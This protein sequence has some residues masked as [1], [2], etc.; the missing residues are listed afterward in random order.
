MPKLPKL[1]KDVLSV[2]EILSRDPLDELNKIAEKL[3]PDELNQGE[4]SDLVKMWIALKKRSIC[5]DTRWIYMFLH[6]AADANSLPK[7]HNMKAEDK[8]K[9]SEKV[10]SLASKLAKELERNDLDCH[11][12]FENGL[13]Y[14]GFYIYEDFS[15][16]FQQSV[17]EDNAKKLKVSSF[18]NKI[19][20]RAAQKIKDEP[21]PG[22]SGENAHAIRFIRIISNRNKKIYGSPLLAVTAAAANAIFGTSYE[23]SDISNFLNR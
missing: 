15:D 16:T 18:M 10:T 8:R 6:A 3:I 19:A 13:N 22:K 9:L 23:E 7:F 14:N 4:K 21:L 5:D 11:L 1:P 20:E 17:D 12:I 2:K